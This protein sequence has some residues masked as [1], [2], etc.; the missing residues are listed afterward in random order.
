MTPKDFIAGHVTRAVAGPVWHAD[1]LD[2]ILADVT[3]AEAGA[4]PIPGAHNIAELVAHVSVW[5]A[6]AERRLVG[7]NANPTDEENFPTFSQPTDETWRS[8]LQLLRERH[9][10]LSRAIARL[11]ENALYEPV[12]FRD[13]SV[14]YMLHGV[15]EH[16]AYHAGQIALLKKMVR[17][18]S[19]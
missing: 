15:V 7:E 19:A 18:V 5:A 10:S 3:A 12:A 8:A 6:I 11:E 4:R 16:D 17:L 14:A 1:A 9:A 13:Y 2:Q